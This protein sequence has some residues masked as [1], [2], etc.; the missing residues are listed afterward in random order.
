MKHFSLLLIC[1]FLFGSINAQD[2]EQKF[3]K[4]ASKAKIVLKNGEIKRGILFSVSRESILYLPDLNRKS[5]IDW[6]NREFKEISVNQIER[7]SL[8]KQDRFLLSL[9]IGV[10]VGLLGD[11]IINPSING[12]SGFDPYNVVPNDEGPRIPI[13]SD[14]P[15][16]VTIPIISAIVGIFP[17]VVNIKG[18]EALDDLQFRKLNRHALLIFPQR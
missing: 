11:L 17:F 9:G 7:I 10:G 12:N 5:D 8:K 4:R 13:F 14:L 1:L 2:S 6:E 18:V 16:S 15:L 3:R